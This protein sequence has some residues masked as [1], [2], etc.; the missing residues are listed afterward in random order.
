MT[1]LTKVHEEEKKQ[2]Q[3]KLERAEQQMKQQKYQRKE[4]LSNVAEIQS[5][6]LSEIEQ[7]NGNLSKFKQETEGELFQVK[8]ERDQ[9]INRV[10]DLEKQLDPVRNKAKLSNKE[11]ESRES[12]RIPSEIQKSRHASVSAKRDKSH[13]R[14]SIL[15]QS[16]Q[17]AKERT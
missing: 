14:S 10:A 1:R 13:D 6:Y 11:P 5:K 7:L 2:I 15:N 4:R 9:A 3:S 16:V 17:S 8:L 12:L